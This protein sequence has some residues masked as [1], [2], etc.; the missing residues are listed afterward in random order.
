MLK[1]AWFKIIGL[2]ITIDIDAIEENSKGDYRFVSHNNKGTY[3]Q[4]N[5]TMQA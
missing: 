2:F 1:I 4:Q 3:K 5:L